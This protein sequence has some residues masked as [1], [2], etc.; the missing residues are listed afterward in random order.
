MRMM[1]LDEL[2]TAT[3]TTF[4]VLKQWRHRD[5]IALS[6]GQRFA[7]ASL[8][9]LPLDGIGLLLADAVAK[10]HGRTFAAQAVRVHW[11]TWAEVVAHAEDDPTRPANFCVVDF[12][13]ADGKQGHMVCG[14]AG[15]IDEEALALRLAM[16]PQAKG[17]EPERI[18]CVNV[19]RL[20]RFMRE[21]AARHGIDLLDRFL[22]PPGDPALVDLLAPW[23]AAK[24]SAIDMA[25]ALRRKDEI[26]AERAGALVRSALEGKPGGATVQ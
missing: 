25:R 5:Q 24:E 18:V 15:A 11:D 16:T 2:L 23:K 12:R 9:Y 13:L 21:N 10:S 26:A 14:A 17:A 1:T 20:I 4:N 8:R 22:P 19:A 3:A 7:Y 6:F